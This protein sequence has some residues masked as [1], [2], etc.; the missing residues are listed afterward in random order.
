MMERCLKVDNASELALSRR[1]HREALNLSQLL[2]EV[3]VRQL[4]SEDLRHT[5]VG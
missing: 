3:E 4:I 5:S 2:D 1:N